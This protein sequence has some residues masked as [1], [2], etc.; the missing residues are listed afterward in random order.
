MAFLVKITDTEGNALRE[1]GVLPGQTVKLRA[2]EERVVLPHVDPGAAR[3]ETV[4]DEVR[5]SVNGQEAIAFQGFTIYLE[6]GTLALTFGEEGDIFAVNSFDS[7][8]DLEGL[9]ELETTAGN[10]T[11]LASGGT[12]S[13]GSVSSVNSVSLEPLEE[14]SVLDTLPT[15][16]AS[17]HLLDLDGQG[18]DDAVA[19]VVTETQFKLSVDEGADLVRGADDANGDDPVRTDL[20]RGSDGDDKL[21]GEPDTKDTFIL[22]SGNDEIEDFKAKEGDRLDIGNVFD[23]GA[24]LTLKVSNGDII[25]KFDS[26]GD[27]EKDASTT[28]KDVVNNATTGEE[29]GQDSLEGKDYDNLIDLNSALKELLGVDSTHPDIV[30]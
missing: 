16:L 12:G 4:G 21:E 28:L 15:S 22:S 6:N 26:D 17:A 14:G 2:G 9:D 11:S 23:D 3:V 20:I 25:L 30:V 10:K 24:D 27:D 19:T 7:L 29:T 1:I 18:G 13:D 5:I 8:L